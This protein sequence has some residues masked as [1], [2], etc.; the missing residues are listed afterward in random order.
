MASNAG[1]VLALLGT[2]IGLGCPIAIALGLTAV[3]GIGLQ[4]GLTLLPTI[5]DIV[6]NTGNSFTLVAIPMFILMGEII[7][8]TGVSRR[9][10][11]GLATLLG[12]VPGGL[13]HA[14]VVG[15]ALFSAIS[16][17]SVATALTMGQ[18]ALPELQR[19][20]YG[21]AST[22]GSLAAGGTLGILIRRASR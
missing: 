19:R 3:A 17:S 9:F 13:A 22:T 8:Q 5:G 21:T 11:R 16:G 10:Y 7:L 4:H 18:V 15:G 20:N 12:R 6:W 2:L 14:N 1:V